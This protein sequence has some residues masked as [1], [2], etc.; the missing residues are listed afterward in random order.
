MTK[1]GQMYS[2]TGLNADNKS[3]QSQTIVLR[4]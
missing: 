3:L 4:W 2:K 1:A